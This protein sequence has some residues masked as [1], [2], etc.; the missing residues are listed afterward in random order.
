MKIQR[1]N[2]KQCLSSILD[3][4]SLVLQAK[5]IKQLPPNEIRYFIIVTTGTIHVLDICLK[6]FPPNIQPVLLLNAMK[7]WEKDFIEENYLA[8]KV[9]EFNSLRRAMIPHGK[10][11]DFLFT[12]HNE[13]FGIIDSDS[14]VFDNTVFT[15]MASLQETTI[16]NAC[17][18]KQIGVVP[19]P[20]TFMLFF[21][22]SLVNE[23][24]KKYKIGS[25]EICYD[26]IPIDAR[27][28][29][30]KLGI[31]QQH[32]PDGRDFFDTL[33]LLLSLGIADGYHVNYINI[34]NQ[35]PGIERGVYHVGGIT[36]RDKSPFKKLNETWRFRRA[37][38]WY[39]ALE[40]Q[41]ND[42]IRRH[43]QQEYGTLDPDALLT[44]Y[45][46]TVQLIGQ[47]FFTNTEKIISQQNQD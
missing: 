26:R 15:K 16:V 25:G 18:K 31:D 6:Y 35:K 43:Y 34:Q 38:F 24:R 47:D 20:Q 36:I 12:F 21:N 23:I 17:F 1:T 9:I 4:I 27:N 29:L 3:S 39:R 30:A 28:T 32:Y 22:T 13:P 45:P 33:H 37:Y 11:L 5:A 46:L 19:L 44:Q 7:N 10:I 2:L 41:K 42:E 14:F 8:Y 40:V